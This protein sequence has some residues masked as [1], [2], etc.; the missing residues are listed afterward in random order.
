PIVAFLTYLTVDKDSPRDFPYF[1]LAL[2]SV[3]FGTSIAAREIIKERAVYNR[4]RMVNLGLLPYVGSKLLVLSLI[5]GLQCILLFGSLRVLQAAGLMELP[6]DY[7][8]VPQLLVMILTGM[9]GIALGLFISAIVKT[10]EMATSFVPLMLIPQLLF[11]GLVGVPKGISKYVG[12]IMPATWAYD[13][14]KRF[15]ALPVLRGKDE[16]AEPAAENEGRGLYKDIRYQ[17]DQL[18]DQKQKEVEDYKSKSEHKFDDF[19][20]EMNTYQKD[21]EKWNMGGRRGTEPKKP[22]KPKLDPVP[23]QVKVV[24]MPDDLSG[25][26]DFLHPWGNRWLN[27]AVLLLM[28]LGLT[29]GTILALRSQDIG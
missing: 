16:Q 11:C 27:P 8:G 18:V 26:V 1:V 12:V 5:V 23:P 19:D 17:N 4:E 25:Y 14:M 3:W 13:E 2:V 7:Y 21:L 20:K 29:C 22:K 6:G 10:S 9:V 28:F 15:S 24:Q